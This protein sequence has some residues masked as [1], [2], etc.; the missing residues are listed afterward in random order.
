MK[1]AL[2]L[3]FFMLLATPVC[4]Q[5]A[6]ISTGTAAGVQPPAKRVPKRKAVPAPKAAEPAAGVQPEEE[7]AV[8]IDARSDE[9]DP[10]R[11][12]DD[13]P[14]EPPETAR[15]AVP[16]GI[17]SSYGQIKGAVNDG[18]RS[19]LIFEN[20]EGAVSFVQIFAGKNAVSWKLLSRIYRSRD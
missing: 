13:D 7:G 10:G 20:E 8:M 6:E 4:A 17:P 1:S 12:S 2:S 16:D 3:V 14:S 18:G 5:P 19:L 15:P 9:N 11:F